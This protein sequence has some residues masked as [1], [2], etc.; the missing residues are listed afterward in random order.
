[1]GI[2]WQFLPMVEKAF[3]RQLSQEKKLQKCA[4]LQGKNY[5]WKGKGDGWGDISS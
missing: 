1:M 3:I 2:D 4:D 5:F